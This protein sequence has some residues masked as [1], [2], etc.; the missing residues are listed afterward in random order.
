VRL[1]GARSGRLFPVPALLLLAT[2]LAAGLMGCDGG[3]QGLGA[4][5]SWSGVAVQSDGAA[6]YVGSRDGR[7][8]KVGIEAD[9]GGDLT[10]RAQAEF[11][12]ASDNRFE[13]SSGNRVESAFYGTP[14]LANGRVYAGSYQGFVYSLSEDL[15][16]VG[17]FEIPGDDLLAKGITG[18]V[19]VVDGRVVV[20]ASENAKT[21]RLYVLDAVMLDADKDD[22]DILR[23]G[24]RYPE[25][26]EE[27]IGPIWSTPTVVDGI[28][29]FGD[30]HHFI[31]AVSIWDCKLLWD[32]PAEVGGALVAPPVV[33]GGRLYI[34]S[35]DRSMYAVALTT[36]AV[37]KL[38][39]A[40][41]WFWAGAVTDGQRVY[42]PNLDGRLYAYDISSGNLAWSY[43]Q[44]GD[45]DPLLSS[46]AV[47]GD[48]IVLAS[49]S[50]IL[51]LLDTS[52]KRL[53][54]LG[55]TGDS[56]R[57]SLTTFDDTVF[58]RSLD[59][60]IRPYRVKNGDLDSDPD[61]ELKLEGF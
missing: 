1:T 42:A 54:R 30:L 46:P 15:N 22:E 44:E 7:I 40:D 26:G 53:D 45:R 41:N 36:G 48:K 2:L 13:E 5:Q 17:E 56:V 16:D 10:L 32:A 9:G 25:D 51:T 18:S 27:S 4:S 6:G 38:F 35:F 49:D 14:T 3:R 43:D 8:I 50:G 57:S 11:D 12:A 47:I 61:W 21:G 19:V 20:A 23:E 24:C 39:T 52:G 59:E 60:V 33:A 55:T 29:Y 34:G 28:A 58:A 37:T 31:H